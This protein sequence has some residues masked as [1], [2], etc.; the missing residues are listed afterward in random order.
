MGALILDASVLIGLL[1]TADAHHQQAVDDVDA[2]D[3]AGEA[4]LVPAS[5]Y[6]E[7]LVAF[8]RA[9]RLPG[10]R[11]AIAGMGIT[12]V[13]LDL[14]IAERAAE[15]RAEHGRLRLPDAMVLATA[16]ER[17]AALLTYDDTLARIA[18]A[19]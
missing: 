19:N 4:L 14:E 17:A 5:A 2:A 3:R 7:A 11:E 9:G 1:D 13:A 15:L 16:R 10:A 18:R 6:S 8:A 12:I